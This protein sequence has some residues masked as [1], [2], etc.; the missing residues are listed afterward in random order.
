[1]DKEIQGTQNKQIEH[2]GE[3]REAI[4]QALEAKLP[5]QPRI[6]SAPSPTAAEVAKQEQ[7]VEPVEAKEDIISNEEK[8]F[9]MLLDLFNQNKS[10]LRVTGFQVK[11]FLELVFPSIDIDNVYSSLK[12]K[13]YVP[14]GKD[15][16]DFWLSYKTSEESRKHKELLIPLLEKVAKIAV[17]ALNRNELMERLLY[18]SYLNKWRIQSYYFPKVTEGLTETDRILATF[19]FSDDFQKLPEIEKAVRYLRKRQ[20]SLVKEKLEELCRDIDFLKAIAVLEL[21]QI[22]QR[23]GI[24]VVTSVYYR[25]YIGNLS[26][27]LQ[28]KTTERVVRDLLLLGITESDNLFGVDIQGVLAKEENISRIREWLVF[29]EDE[30]RRTM[31][32][33]WDMFLSTKKCVEG[34]APSNI[35]EF[36]KS[37]AL[38]ISKDK[39]LVRKELKEIYE[40]VRQ[41]L[42]NVLNERV[43]DYKNV[44]IM[45]F[46]QRELL[47][48]LTEKIVIT[49]EAEDWLISENELANNIVLKISPLEAGFKQAKADRQQNREFNALGKVDN[50][51]ELKTRFGQCGWVSEDENNAVKKVREIIEDR[52][53][54]IIPLDEAIEHL[55]RGVSVEGATLQGGVLLDALITA[56]NKPTN[57]TAIFKKKEFGKH[58]MWAVVRQV[59]G[60]R[61]DLSDEQLKLVERVV[62]EAIEKGARIDLL[63]L[64]SRSEGTSDSGEYYS[65]VTDFLAKIFKIAKDVILS[66]IENG[67]AKFNQRQKEI[68]WVYLSYFHASQLNVNLSRFNQMYT[69]IF[70]RRGTLRLEEVIDAI[71]SSGFSVANGISEDYFMERPYHFLPQDVVRTFI[72]RLEGDI[73]AKQPD[74]STFIQKCQDN[75]IE[76]IGLDYILSS[77]GVS[78]RDSLRNFLW[79]VSVE[80][81]NKFESV[82]G[83]ISPKEEETILVNPS[84]VP[85]LKQFL[86]TRKREIVKGKV[87]LRD[88]LLS[89]ENIDRKLDLNE[90]LGVYQGYVITPTKEE[91]KILIAPWYMPYHEALLEGKA[92]LAVVNQPAYGELVNALRGREQEVTLVFLKEKCFSL[93][94]TFSDSGMVDTIVSLFQKHFNLELRQVESR[95]KAQLQIQESAKPVVQPMPIGQVEIVERVE[96]IDVSTAEEPSLVIPDSEQ[97][98]VDLFEGLPFELTPSGLGL[99]ADSAII[100]AFGFEDGFEA[101]RGLGRLEIRDRGRDPS[102]VILCKEDAEKYKGS[103]S[104]KDFWL[105]KLRGY[106]LVSLTGWD[107]VDDVISDRE[108]VEA[109]RSGVEGEGFKFILLDTKAQSVQF[110]EDDSELTERLK[111]AL[112]SGRVALCK[113]KANED[114]KLVLEQF[115]KILNVSKKS[116]S[117]LTYPHDNPFD[118]AWSLLDNGDKDSAIQG[119]I[120]ELSV[121]PKLRKMG[122]FGQLQGESHEHFAMK[123]LAAW[124]LSQRYGNE[125]Q[126]SMEMEFEKEVTSGSDSVEVWEERIEKD[127]KIE[128]EKGFRRVDLWLKVNGE[129]IWLEC[130]TLKNPY[131]P[132]EALRDKLRQIISASD[133]S[134]MPSQIWVMVPY[135]KSILYQKRLFEPLRVVSNFR[136]ANNIKGLRPRLIVADMRNRKLLRIRK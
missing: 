18:L 39:L 20:P 38:L 23:L 33:D 9:L 3:E 135:R 56:I 1:M 132:L 63:T 87:D 113:P 44:I 104:R 31:R 72:D 41:S 107:K 30:F 45:P 98:L 34:P 49:L 129:E 100:C 36:T 101:L 128:V 43:R 60:A 42:E 108:L 24:E 66:N 105:G 126:F 69:L 118:S 16:D 13:Q 68:L 50:I 121:T 48:D 75:P 54:P 133:E 106:R 117:R 86:N 120:D 52:R 85:E 21:P 5:T 78:K 71:N 61:H 59:V 89:L 76:L 94:S 79:K 111:A 32:D 22:A 110:W 91:I 14:A 103:L 40:E 15:S 67:F 124:N 80:A 12:S 2:S 123:L 93:Y 134:K 62:T 88:L 64:E 122:G 130:E 37:G 102:P 26:L 116:K 131:D 125:S 114:A 51:E 136:H 4:E 119:L 29:S 55:K 27:F 97:N 95:E 70:G 90:D 92:I 7:R 83:V 77:E 47:K 10:G 115:A 58:T 96:E 81:W 65:R 17:E 28:D 35:L 6:E 53:R 57:Y 46:Y 84:L 74:L 8:Q 112:R 82:Q 25:D 19:F 109:L 11:D 127:V 99:P 73:G